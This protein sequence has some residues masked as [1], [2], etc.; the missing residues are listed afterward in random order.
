[1]IQL[2]AKYCKNCNSVLNIKNKR[3]IVRKNFCSKSCNGT[4]NGKK[5][6]SDPDFLIKFIQSS[7]NEVSK[8]KK[9]HKKESHPMWI[10]REERDCKNCGNSFET[11]K[12]T[13]RKYCNKKCSLEKIHSDLLGKNRVNRI[14][15][16]CIICKNFFE[17]S[18]NYKSPAKYCSRKCHCIGILKFSNKKSTNIEMI[19]ENI[20]IDIGLKYDSQYIIKNISIADFKIEDLLI[21]ADGDYWHNLPGRREKDLIQTNKLKKIGYKVIRFDGSL[22]ENN[23]ELVKE[24]IINELC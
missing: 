1:M 20:I 12:N 21:F 16:E 3:D 9:G 23:P 6:M 17:R 2:E 24:K 15:H 13:K 19:I 4:F 8:S 22:I 11:R 7:N 10:E 14:K 5:R 18:E